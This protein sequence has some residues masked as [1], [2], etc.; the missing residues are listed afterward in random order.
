M[1]T[2]IVP[3]GVHTPV[4]KLNKA[5]PPGIDVVID[6]CLRQE[7]D[8]R[9][10][11]AEALG[12]ALDE[13]LA[14]PTQPEPRPGQAVEPLARLDVGKP[15]ERDAAPE[16]PSPPPTAAVR[17]PKVS[18]EPRPQSAAGPKPK[19]RARTAREPQL[20]PRGKAS[21]PKSQAPQFPGGLRGLVAASFGLLII[22]LGLSLIGGDEP[23]KDEARTLRLRKSG[24]EVVDLRPT[25]RGLS[26]AVGG[27]WRRDPGQ[28]KRVQHHAVLEGDSL[29]QRQPAR[30]QEESLLRDSL[31][32]PADYD[33]ENF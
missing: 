29:V 3:E 6:I 10:V 5:L 15:P 14:G 13:A 33:P 12:L 23:L 11:N 31:Y 8:E 19:E 22:G 2:G 27:S 16:N 18:A 20:S 32:K 4:S 9:F 1:L 21:R 26:E 30:A 7:P 24:P 25:V 17:G 28:P